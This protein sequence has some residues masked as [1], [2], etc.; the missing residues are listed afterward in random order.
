M[1]A[2]CLAGILGAFFGSLICFISFVCLLPRD[3]NVLL[4]L[5][6]LG[7]GCSLLVRAFILA[8]S[9]GVTRSNELGAESLILQGIAWGVGLSAGVFLL[10]SS[11]SGGSRLSAWPQPVP[12]SLVLVSEFIGSCIRSLFRSASAT[13]IPAP[14]L[15]GILSSCE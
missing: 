7:V 10:G 5:R 9:T 1:R 4:K 11:F 6:C 15:E 14:P 3:I 8:G 13:R 2:L 12:A